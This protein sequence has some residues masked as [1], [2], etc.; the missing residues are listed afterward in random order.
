MG[1]SL[2]GNVINAPKNF[3]EI[4]ADTGSVKPSGVESVLTIKGDDRQ[5]ITEIDG[6]SL[7]IKH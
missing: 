2:Y 3:S 1:K 5:I 4:G 6:A 7:R